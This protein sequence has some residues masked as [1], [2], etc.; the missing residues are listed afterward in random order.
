MKYLS[1]SFDLFFFLDKRDCILVI[2]CAQSLQYRA[3]IFQGPEIER[4]LQIRY[5]KW[6]TIQIH[7]LPQ[8]WRQT[9]PPNSRYL[10]TKLNDV[11]S[12]KTNIDPEPHK[13]ARTTK[14]I[15]YAWKNNQHFSVW[16]QN[17]QHF[18]TYLQN[19]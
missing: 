19:N 1:V 5:T 11:A 8:G 7:V 16:L 4:K 10:C 17:N 6:M 9:F 3:H 2:S 15:M 14:I 12:Q 13:K 18:Y